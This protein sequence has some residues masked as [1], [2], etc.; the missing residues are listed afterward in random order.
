VDN[1]D[2]E[3]AI[4]ARANGC[5]IDL[6][7]VNVLVGC[8]GLGDLVDLVGDLFGGGGTVG[9]V[10]LDT[11]VVLGTY[12]RSAITSTKSHAK[13]GLFHVLRAYHQGCD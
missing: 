8:E 2:L 4:A 9:K 5:G 1:L 11:K 12:R 10:V 13:Q 6:G 7:E 3:R